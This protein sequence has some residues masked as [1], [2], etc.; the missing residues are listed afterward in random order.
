MATN[1]IGIVKLYKHQKKV[2]EN[3]DIIILTSILATLFIV[4]GIAM[5]KEFS[6]M[7]KNGYKYDPNSKKYGR[8]ALLIFMQRLFDDET[9]KKMT[10]K[11]KRVMLSSVKRTIADMESDG[12][13]FPE[14][15]K[16]ELIKQREE[17]HCEY[18]GL[19]S[20]KAYEYVK[21]GK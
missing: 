10:K 19:P 21:E 3:L 9:T 14:D 11:E 8:E 4:F 13:Y 7:E 12:I 20:V 5:Y 1:H 18:S 6:N 16:E 2:M 17:L 15:V